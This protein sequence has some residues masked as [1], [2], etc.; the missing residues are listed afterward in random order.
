MHAQTDDGE[1]RWGPLRAG[2]EPHQLLMSVV[3]I[4]RRVMRDRNLPQVP[5]GQC[6]YTAIARASGGVQFFSRRPKMWATPVPAGS[7]MTTAPPGRRMLNAGLGR[8]T[9]PVQ[10]RRVDVLGWLRLELSGS[11]D[12]DE[13]EANRFAITAS[14]AQ[15]VFGYSE[16]AAGDG[17]SGAARGT[18]VPGAALPSPSGR[19]D[20]V[21]QPDV[22]GAELLRR[23]RKLKSGRDQ[24]RGWLRK[25]EAET[26]IPRR[27]LQRKLKAARLEA[28]SRAEPSV[29]AWLG[30]GRVH[31]LSDKKR[32]PAK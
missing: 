16:P 2:P 25:L 19:G 17:E 12:L 5:A 23:M 20:G 31:N 28:E 6:V 24:G 9:A 11:V 14:D 18:A 10:Q 21:A 8:R 30:G 22:P 26:G 1:T 3:D 29:P 4:L 13:T 27:T 7:V 32:N 15:R